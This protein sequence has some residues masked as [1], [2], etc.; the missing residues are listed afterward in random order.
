LEQLLGRAPNVIADHAQAELMFRLV[1]DSA[2]VRDA[3]TAAVQGRVEVRERFAR[4]R[5]DER[6]EWTEDNGCGVHD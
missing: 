1:G 6:R 4:K 3:L 2:V 5:S